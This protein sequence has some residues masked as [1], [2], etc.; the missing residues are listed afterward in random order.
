[1]QP[2]REPRPGQDRSRQALGMGTIDKG[3][4][5][6][7]DKDKDQT[8]MHDSP[9]KNVSERVVSDSEEPTELGLVWERSEMPTDKIG[10]KKNDGNEIHN[11]WWP[12]DEENNVSPSQALSP[13]LSEEN[14]VAPSE[15]PSPHL[16]E[17]E[18][19]LAQ[20]EARKNVVA[21]AQGL[22]SLSQSCPVLSARQ[23]RDAFWE[24][25]LQ[26]E[27]KRLQD[28]ITSR[29]SDSDEDDLPIVNT[30]TSPAAP[31]KKKKRAPKTLWTY[32]AVESGS[33]TL[34]QLLTEEGCVLFLSN[35]KS[36]LVHNKSRSFWK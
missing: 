36:S 20:A 14:N 29:E 31:N 24:S 23:Q 9:N 26:S 8:E 21:T 18:D 22:L 15:A 27:K 34:F 1:M 12:D 19:Y 25:H 30:L 17:F 13:H 32:E 4:P 33:V 16:S 5:R 3:I 35:F 28:A 6:S 7:K 2:F 10:H 11:P